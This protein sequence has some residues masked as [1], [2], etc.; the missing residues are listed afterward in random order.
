MNVTNDDRRSMTGERISIEKRTS[1][2]AA[3]S[4]HSFYANNR[5]NMTI[6]GVTDVLS[7]DENSVFLVTTCGKLSLEGDDLHVTVLNT[8][9][10]MI[11]VTGKLYG[12]LYDDQQDFPNGSNKHKGKRGFF[13]RLLS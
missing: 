11:E 5:E 6:R 7:F 1:E 12:L 2:S 3:A 9:D 13:G 8:K 10:G 4:P